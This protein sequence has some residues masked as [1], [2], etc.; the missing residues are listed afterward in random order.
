MN[1]RIYSIP[2][3]T[4][5]FQPHFF[6]YNLKELF[7][8]TNDKYIT[9]IYL[10]FRSNELIK[11]GDIIASLPYYN[12]ELLVKSPVNGT[13]F[14]KKNKDIDINHICHNYFQLSFD[15][16]ISLHNFQKLNIGYVVK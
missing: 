6:K 8:I 7:P 5:K 3:I 15:K 10:N 9:E 11:K 2:F 1:I 4:K 13:F 14:L 12:S 16:N